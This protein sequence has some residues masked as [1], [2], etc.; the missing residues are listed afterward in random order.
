MFARYFADGVMG[1]AGW[2]RKV[3]LFKG[4]GYN[5]MMVDVALAQSMEW[6]AALGA[7][8]PRLALEMLAEMFSDRDCEG[9]NAPNVKMFV[10]GATE[11]WSTAASPQEAIKPPEFSDGMSTLSVALVAASVEGELSA[12]AFAVTR[13]ER[14]RHV[15]SVRAPSWLSDSTSR[16][17]VVIALVH[18]LRRATALRI[19]RIAYP[20]RRPIR[21][22]TIA[23]TNN[24][25]TSA[26]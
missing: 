2:P 19:H 22:P 11:R 5:A 7:G 23:L 9:D 12:A 25:L 17:S 13:D 21:K 4:K 1:Q 18:R 16:P 3:G 8:R 14:D 20:T 15:D 10:E 24:R 26:P 6:G